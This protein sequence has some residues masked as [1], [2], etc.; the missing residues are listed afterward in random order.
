MSV[1]ARSPDTSTSMLERRARR[2]FPLA[3]A[4]EYRLLG[5]VERR[6]WGQTR[7]IS[8][9]GVLFEAA[10]RQPLSGAIELLVSWPCV[11]N[12]ACAMKLLMKGRIVRMEGRGVA[13][14]SSQHEFRT[15]GPARS[16]KLQDLKLLTFRP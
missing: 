12:E 7:N 15:A 13:M 8:S 2:R 10:D 3:L 4:V 6:G 16:S 9:T 11:L 5:K 1:V 14:V